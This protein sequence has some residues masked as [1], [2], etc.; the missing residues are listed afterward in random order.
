MP[1]IPGAYLWEMAVGEDWTAISTVT[2]VSKANL[3]LANKGHGF[4]YNGTSFNRQPVVGEVVHL[5]LA[6]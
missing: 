2:G 5:P 3:A 1:R 6:P 4:T